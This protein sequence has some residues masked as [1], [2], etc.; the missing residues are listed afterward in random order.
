MPSTPSDLAGILHLPEGS[1]TIWQPA[2]ESNYAAHN[3]GHYSGVPRRFVAVC[4][5]TP[6][7]TWDDYE[8]TPDLF[9]RP[10]F[11]A[12]T[13]YYADSDG[14][15][16]QMVHDRDYAFA[17]GQPH[18][19]RRLPR[20]SW[21][22]DEY[23]SYNTCMLSIEIEGRA[24]QIASTF[25]P[26]QPQFLTVAAWLAFVCTKYQIEINR[27]FVIGHGELDTW[28][29]D[30]GAEFPWLPLLQQAR[31]MASAYEH[32][33]PADERLTQLTQSLDTHRQFQQ[34]QFDDLLTRIG[35]LTETVRILKDNNYRLR[36]D[37]DA[38]HDHA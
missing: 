38:H 4:L 21:W 24:A 36:R 6:E 11:G 31:T 8:L 16:Y 7:E 5:H 12:S 25:R 17:Q 2:H 18:T 35:D 30:P 3:S 13:G 29:T 32:S 28:R 22:R 23:I 10:N 9:S 34:H 27:T 15:L 26:G 19:Q 14:D 33:Q 37:F 20:P 1:Q